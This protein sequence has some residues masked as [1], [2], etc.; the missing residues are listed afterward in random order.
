MAHICKGVV[1]LKMS[2]EEEEERPPGEEEEED[3]EE[4]IAEKKPTVLSTSVENRP[5][6]DLEFK[7]HD[8]LT[9]ALK[10]DEET[11]LDLPDASVKSETE[12]PQQTLGSTVSAPDPAESNAQPAASAAPVDPYAG[13]TGY[14]PA[15]AG[16]DYSAYW[17]QYGYQASA[18]TYPGSIQCQKTRAYP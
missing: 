4:V 12:I 9:E 18:Y 6:P 10:S 1:N 2:N 17:A 16:Y 5:E 8:T 15:A 11:K 7:A 13:Y 14:D 3:I